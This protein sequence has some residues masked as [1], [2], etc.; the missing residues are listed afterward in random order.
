ME[1]LLGKACKQAIRSL[2]HTAAELQTEASQR[3]CGVPITR[4]LCPGL[5]QQ[6]TTALASLETI[7]V[8]LERT[9]QIGRENDFY[10]EVSGVCNA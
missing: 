7:P 8:V 4:M 1:A 3:V 9:M 5:L 10:F 6:L 2:G